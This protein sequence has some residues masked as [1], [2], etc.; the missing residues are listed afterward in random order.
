MKWIGEKKKKPVIYWALLQ[1]ARGVWSKLDP[2]LQ[3]SMGLIVLT[4]IVYS[5]WVCLPQHRCIN[6]TDNV[7]NSQKLTNQI[8]YRVM[9]C[10]HISDGFGNVWVENGT[11]HLYFYFE[12]LLHI[13][14]W[15]LLFSKSCSQW[16]VC[17]L[18]CPFWL[19]QCA[20]CCFLAPN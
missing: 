5:G 13:Q 19:T 15:L 11:Y 17:S 16:P 14:I 18:F 7:K 12:S 4:D 20:E 2:N 1:I 9:S 10:K 6:H 8:W 3:F